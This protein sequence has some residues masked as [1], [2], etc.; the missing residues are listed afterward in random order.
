M[1]AIIWK[2]IDGNEYFYGKYEYSTKDERNYVN[3][4]SES[5]RDMEGVATRIERVE[6]DE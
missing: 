3:C 6:D 4:L 5:I 1:K 2:I